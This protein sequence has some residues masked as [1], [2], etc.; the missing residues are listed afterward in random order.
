MNPR[1]WKEMIIASRKLEESLGS[2]I[3][4]VE[5]NER[6][7]VIL[8]RRSVRTN[9]IIKKG[10]KIKKKDLCFL[11]P[12][13]KNSLRPFEFYKVINKKAKKKINCHEII[14]LQNVK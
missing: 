12:C 13:P 9:R 6:L 7:T 1:S 8:Q 2:N 14:N 3:K 5:K 4:K 11:R 10:E